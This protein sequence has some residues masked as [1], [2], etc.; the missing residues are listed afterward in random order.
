LLKLDPEN[1]TYRNN[2]SL[3][4][5]GRA[6]RAELRRDFTAAERAY[7]EANRLLEGPAATNFMKFNQLFN[8]GGMAR[9]AAGQ[10]READAARYLAQVRSLT[11]EVNSALAAESV[12]RVLSDVTLATFGVGIDFERGK[13]AEVRKQSAAMVASLTA[14]RN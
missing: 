1:A 12:D 11:A 10:G 14:I 2:V 4:S 9:L 3:G 7:A 8:S 5:A 6:R 13:L